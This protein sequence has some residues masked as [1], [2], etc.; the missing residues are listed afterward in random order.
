MAT[1]AATDERGVLE[2]VLELS[3]L[4]LKAMEESRLEDLVRCQEERERLLIGFYAVEERMP[5]AALKPIVDEVLANDKKLEFT[6]QAA[7]ADMKE[8]LLSLN[9]GVTA[10]KAYGR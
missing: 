3:K 10:L 1:D 6:I 7:M 5:D 2:R 4:Q 8:K 9:N